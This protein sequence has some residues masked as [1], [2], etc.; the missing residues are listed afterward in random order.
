MIRTVLQPGTDPNKCIPLTATENFILNQKQ[1]LSE[2]IRSGLFCD[3][4]PVEDLIFLTIEFSENTGIADCVV[5]VD[6][7]RLPFFSGKLPALARVT[8]LRI[9]SSSDFFSAEVITDVKNNSVITFLIGLEDVIIELQGICDSR[10]KSAVFNKRPGTDAMNGISQQGRVR[11]RLTLRTSQDAPTGY[12]Q[13]DDQSDDMLPLYFSHKL[14]P[15]RIARKIR[16]A[17]TNTPTPK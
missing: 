13:T 15:L 9:M 4:K 10:R 12:E 5:A 14:N 1:L 2:G 11:I 6:P 8:N 16:M 7:L 3:L 17:R